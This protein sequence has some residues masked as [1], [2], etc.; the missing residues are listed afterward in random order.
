MAQ[1]H[2]KIVPHSFYLSKGFVSHSWQWLMFA[3]HDSNHLFVKAKVGGKR[4]R[5][6]GREI[7]CMCTDSFSALCIRYNLS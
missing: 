1:M 5:G 6:D 3:G 7:A 2:V 4:G